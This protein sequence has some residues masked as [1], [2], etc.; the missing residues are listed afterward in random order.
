MDTKWLMIQPCLIVGLQNW[1]LELRNVFKWRLHSS[2]QSDSW[3]TIISVHNYKFAGLNVYAIIY[4]S[5][6]AIAE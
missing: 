6:V 5:F 4:L 2:L 1:N 3:H